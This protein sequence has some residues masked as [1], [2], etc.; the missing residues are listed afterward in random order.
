M[1]AISDRINLTY[2]DHR[3]QES[4]LPMRVLVISDL[5]VDERSE[6]VDPENSRALGRNTGDILQHWKISFNAII[7]NHLQ[8]ELDAATEIRYPITAIDDFHPDNLMSGIP[9]LNQAAALYIMLTEEKVK[10][11]EIQPL[12]E[13]FG[14]S[15]SSFD[16]DSERLLIQ[17][18]LEQR[19]QKQLNEI[20]HHP[21]FRQ[22]ERSWRSVDFLSR[23]VPAGENIEVVLLNASKQAVT[24]DFEDVPDVTQSALY[25]LVYRQ[26]FGQLGGKPYLMMVADFDISEKAQDIALIRNM[27]ALAAMA[28][29]PVAANAAP[30][31]FGIKTFAELP[32]V[33]DLK[34]HFDQPAY[35][36]WNG[37]RAHHDSRYVALTLPRFLLRERYENTGGGVR[38]T[39]ASMQ[40][41]PGV[42]GSSSFAL[43]SVFIRSFARY[44]WFVNV[45]GEEYGLIEEIAIA[46]SNSRIRNI[47]PTEVMISDRTLSELVNHGFTPLSIYKSSR[48]AGFSAIPAC[49]N[50]ESGEEDS[51]FD[52]PLSQKLDSQLP[53]IMISCRFSHYLKILQREN[54]GAWKTRSQIDQS[55]N[56]WLRQYVS[57]MDS[58]SPGVRAKR[59]LRA[60][61]I[62]VREM[63]GKGAWYLIRI[64]LTP[65]FKFMGNMFTLKERG[66]LDK[67]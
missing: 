2:S 31:L 48:T 37:F 61:N 28:H 4:E 23:Q 11:R 44:R 22:L 57:D 52:E 65:H 67:A 25:D 19:I 38:F 13:L 6:V 7:T 56:N 14:Y 41:S 51:S 10:S 59:P 58:P 60:A 45:T 12:F 20:I 32:S 50:Q 16:T 39:E 40:S 36:K 21:V 63:E 55:L 26:E 8:P 17:A 15:D 30:S 62:S 18:D 35:A 33:R 29:C 46:Q 1:E 3:Q 43:A 49:C 53:F 64:T 9:L 5:T 54:I 66:R 42:W 47:I 34:A 24:E 27:A